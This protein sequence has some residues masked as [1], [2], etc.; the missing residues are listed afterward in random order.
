MP[1][2]CPLI[3]LIVYSNEN[4][5]KQ[6]YNLFILFLDAICIEKPKFNTMRMKAENVGNKILKIM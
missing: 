3:S 2:V 5:V 6:F 4:R 1:I